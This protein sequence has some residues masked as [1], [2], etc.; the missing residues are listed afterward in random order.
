MEALK[1]CIGPSKQLLNVKRE[2]SNKPIDIISNQ[3]V[4]TK[5]CKHESYYNRAGHEPSIYHQPSLT[6]RLLQN[7][8]D[9]LVAHP[10]GF[11]KSRCKVGLRLLE[12]VPVAPEIAETDALAPTLD[13]SGVSRPRMTG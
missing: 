11:R 12:A 3:E 8:L 9:H 6:I 5:A 13:E 1:N 4:V 2:I 7:G 10:G